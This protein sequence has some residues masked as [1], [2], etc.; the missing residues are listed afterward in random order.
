VLVI[1]QADLLLAMQDQLQIIVA[2]LQEVLRA[3]L[4]ADSCWLVYICEN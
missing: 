3:A 1:E 2:F 4:L